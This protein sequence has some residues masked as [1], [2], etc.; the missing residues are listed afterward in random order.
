[1]DQESIVHCDEIGTITHPGGATEEFRTSTSSSIPSNVHSLGFECELT[2]Y[3]KDVLVVIGFTISGLT[4]KAPYNDSNTLGLLLCNND[5]RTV[6]YG[7]MAKLEN[8]DQFKNGDIIGVLLKRVVIA[9]KKYS[10]FELCLNGIKIGHPLLSDTLIETAYPTIWMDEP[11]FIINANLGSKPFQYDT[12]LG[13]FE[14][15]YKYTA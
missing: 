8:I 14:C 1:M 6:Q 12:F 7:K 10:V 4:G 9:G 3:T 15:S 5:P 2:N 11:G 13:T